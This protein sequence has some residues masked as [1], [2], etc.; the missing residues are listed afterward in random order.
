MNTSNIILTIVVAIV[1]IAGLMFGLPKYKVWQ[2][3]MSGKARL[4]EATQSRRIL[5]EQAQAEKEAAVLQAEAIKI[6]GEA[7]Q[8]YPEYRQ[9]EFIGAFGEALKSGTISQII[10]VPT[11]ANIPIME[12]FVQL[13]FVTQC[14]TD[15]EFSMR[16]VENW[17]KSGNV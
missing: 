15:W 14:V 3:E 10:Y 9:Q 5:I 2:Q 13:R 12:I 4:A 1:V 7:A 11:E 8:K 16:R 6:M 17:S